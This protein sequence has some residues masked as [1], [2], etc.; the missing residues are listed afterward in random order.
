MTLER[1]HDVAGGSRTMAITDTFTNPTGT[2]QT[3]SVSLVTVDGRDIDDQ[4]LRLSTGTDWL[5]DGEIPAGGATLAEGGAVPDDGYVAFRDE[6]AA[7]ASTSG[8][9]FVGWERIRP[10]AD[11]A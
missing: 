7:D 6:D 8:H 10:R 3:F 4:E 5:G 1:R 11:A 9:G 2:P